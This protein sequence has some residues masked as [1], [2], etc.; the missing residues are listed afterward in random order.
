MG[1]SVWATDAATEQNQAA[2]RCEAIQQ[3]GL[4][5]SD[6]TLN[7]VEYIT[8]VEQ[9]SS[10]KT[11]SPAQRAAFKPFCK[12]SGYFEKRQGADGKPYAIGVGLS[13]PDEWNG[14]LL[15]QGGGGLNGLIRE[16]LGAYATGDVPAIFRGYAVASTDSGHQSDTIFNTDFFADSDA[17]QNFYSG[18]VVKST[19][20]AKQ[21]LETL[22]QS[23]PQQAYFLGCST[24]GREAMTMSQR[25]PEL[26][27]GIVVG[28]PARQTNYSEIADLWSAKRLR[29]LSEN[30]QTPPFS[31]AKQQAIVAALKAQCDSNDGLADGIISDV[32]GCD[33]EP[34]A[35][36]CKAGESG[37]TCLSGAEVTALEEAFAGPRTADGTQVYPGFFFDT[38]I[39]A[40]PKVGIPG[41]LHAIAGPLGQP[42]MGQAFD[43]GKELA[44]AQH[45]PLAPGNATVT[46]L[47]PFAVKGGKII[48]FHGVSDP[49]FSAKDTL[50]YYQQMRAQSNAA[51][52]DAEWAQFYFVPGMG[53]CRGGAET[54]DHFDML[55]P[56]ANWVETQQQPK[57]V[58]ATGASMPAVSRPLCPYP[59]VATY[60]QGQPTNLAS[61][62]ECK[63]PE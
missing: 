12:I 7:Q 37:D 52:P 36:A 32:E 23:P 3:H 29:Q 34:R 50:A 46:D 40:S 11:L 10:I 27:D 38:G 16:P 26:F 9:L 4:G 33:F 53:H 62:F 61:S 58:I 6:V 21:V 35:L 44:M 25:F 17:L 5:I 19:H 42:R 49:W 13:L 2:S 55:T 59:S 30:P 47:R 15:F 18:A 60:Q 20:L 51:S 48:F 31:E 56:L 41:L 8:S 14:K 63:L 1:G 54:L 22:Y 57:R 24:G 28:A 45:F 43:L 39:S